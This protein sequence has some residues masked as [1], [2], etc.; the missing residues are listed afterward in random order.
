M[1]AQV[2]D[3]TYD[4]YAMTIM[5]DGPLDDSLSAQVFPELKEVG[6]EEEEG[7]GMSKTRVPWG[8]QVVKPTDKS[9]GPEG[10]ILCRGE[11]GS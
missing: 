6:G 7:S 2:T 3:L 8:V 10:R 9:E 5:H 4:F 11:N 1:E